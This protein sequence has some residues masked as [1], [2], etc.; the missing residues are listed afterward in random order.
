M[1]R[2]DPNVV[3]NLIGGRPFRCHSA[4]Y[5]QLPDGRN[6]QQH[7]DPQSL[8]PGLSET[9]QSLLTKKQNYVTLQSVACIH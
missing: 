5:Q 8:N 7:V 3:K 6:N 4:T 2:Y 1:V 9:F